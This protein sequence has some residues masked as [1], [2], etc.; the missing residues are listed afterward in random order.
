MFLI[1][2]VLF[3]FYRRCIQIGQCSRRQL[4]T[5]TMRLKHEDHFKR[6]DGIANEFEM[7]YKNQMHYTLNFG[8]FITIATTIILPG[9]YLYYYGYI[10]RKVNPL[11]FVSSVAI[12]QQDIRWFLIILTIS[13]VLLYRVCSIVTLRVYRHESKW[14]KHIQ[15]MDFQRNAPIAVNITT[16]LVTLHFRYIAVMPGILPRRNE[17]FHFSRG[18]VK[19]NFKAFSLFRGL[20]YT[21]KGRTMLMVPERFR[22]SVDLFDMLNP[23]DSK[24]YKMW[25]KE[26][27]IMVTQCTFQNENWRWLFRMLR[28]ILK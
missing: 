26:S 17:L 21:V 5:K 3:F 22:R 14:V 12:D 1:C 9:A 15:T 25:S 20:T 27:V 18:D 24:K 19:E 16:F 11:E 4:L 6:I 10:G 2:F 28:R 8:K 7:I 13:N 23:A